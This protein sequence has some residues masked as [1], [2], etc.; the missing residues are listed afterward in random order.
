MHKKLFLIPI[1]FLVGISFSI[2]QECG[3]VPLTFEE[4]KNVP[5][6]NNPK[7]L[8]SLINANQDYYISNNNQLERS[9]CSNGPAG[10]PRN[11]GDIVRL[12]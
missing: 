7:Y 9:N 10:L 3:T 4:L 11:S 8:D 2:S 5:W 1:L 6:Y 12:K